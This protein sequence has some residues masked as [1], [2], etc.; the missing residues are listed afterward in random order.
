MKIANQ[1]VFAGDHAKAERTA[2]AQQHAQSKNQKSTAVFAGDTNL[3]NDPIA[4]KRKQAQKQAMKVVSDAFANER[5]I[6]EDLQSR[7]DKILRMQDDIKEYQSQLSDLDEKEDQLKELYAVTDDG[8]E[9]AQNPDYIQRMK[10]LQDFRDPIEKQLDNAQKEIETQVAVIKGVSK[11]RLKSHAMA[12][13][14]SQAKE[15]MDAA[16]GEILGM[17]FEEGKEH[18]DEESEKKL[19]KSERQA[20][21]KEEEKKQTEKIR[22]K[23]KEMQE[24][25]GK[26]AEK[27]PEQ[28]QTDQFDDVLYHVAGLEQTKTEV[29]TEVEHIVDKMNLVIEDIKGSQVD[30]KL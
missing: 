6:D 18:L 9:N 3:A 8:D 28:S 15:I 12:D 7:R 16:S 29:Q 13:A 27:H 1:A 23:A 5:K 11:E 24:I 30:Q 25:T 17:L 20:E 19:E 10:E 14:Q 21:K 22:E 26:A 2:P 4:L